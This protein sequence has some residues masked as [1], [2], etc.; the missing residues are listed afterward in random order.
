MLSWLYSG[1]RLPL[2][3]VHAWL[4]ASYQLPALPS[5]SVGATDKQAVLKVLH[6]CDNIFTR[7][8]NKRHTLIWLGYG[9]IRLV[10]TEVHYQTGLLSS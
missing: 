8:L 5:L 2:I 10:L 9:Y 4:C 7:T 1:L 6:C 3:C